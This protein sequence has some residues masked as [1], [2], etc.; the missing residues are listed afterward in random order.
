METQLAK[1]AEGKTAI[2]KRLDGGH[3]FQGR[4]RL[5]GIQEGKDVKVVTRQL[6]GGPIVIQVEGRQTTIGRGMAHKIIV[7]TPE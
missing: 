5:M 3:K 1:V 2:I 6:A 7:E 4:L